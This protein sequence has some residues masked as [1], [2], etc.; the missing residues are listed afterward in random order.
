MR[1]FSFV[2][3]FVVA[4]IICL[5]ASVSSTSNAHLLGKPLSKISAKNS[6]KDVPNPVRLL[7]SLMTALETK[8]IKMISSLLA[9][10]GTVFMPGWSSVPVNKA[11]AVA[12]L[13]GYF[14]FVNLVKE[15]TFVT[16][17]TSTSVHG[18]WD[19]S[20]IRGVSNQSSSAAAK[21]FA[22][23]VG[24]NPGPDDWHYSF[25]CIFRLTSNAA[26][27]LIETFDAF[28][29]SKYPSQQANVS[30]SI[31]T[32]AGVIKAFNEMDVAKLTSHLSPNVIFDLYPDGPYRCNLQ[33]IQTTL[34]QFFSFVSLKRLKA[35]V[36]GIEVS[37]NYVATLR[38]DLI[39]FNESSQGKVDPEI[40][41]VSDIIELDPTFK[42]RKWKWYFASQ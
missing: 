37:Y 34:T 15:N 18:V 31:A 28:A 17:V 33:C 40:Y 38:T 21:K 36:D 1:A 41:S 25:R 10:N 30:E 8:D 32:V 5:L 35:I 2:A 19:Y 9:D 16:T 12:A 23:F 7:D 3:T 42:I 22:S 26:G 39:V 4:T 20:D 6:G 11:Y 13:T 29:S 24:G 27:T 14:S